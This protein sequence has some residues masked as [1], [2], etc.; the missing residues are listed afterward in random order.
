MREPHDSTRE[1]N[2][3]EGGLPLH[4]LF[5]RERLRAL[6]ISVAER[7]RQAF[8]VVRWRALGGASDC[9]GEIMIAVQD[10]QQLFRQR[11]LRS[12]LCRSVCHGVSEPHVHRRVRRIG[13]LPMMT[14]KE[15]E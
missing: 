10:V 5:S 15:D 8:P 4:E 7:P 1:H 12:D 13:H 14:I 11:Q 9:A 3:S 6:S 2:V